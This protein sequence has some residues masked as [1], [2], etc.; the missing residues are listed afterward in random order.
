[1]ATHNNIH[2]I[3]KH[4]GLGTTEHRH[5]NNVHGLFCLYIILYNF[6]IGKTKKSTMLEV[7]IVVAL[8]GRTDCKIY[9]M[10][11]AV[12]WIEYQLHRCDQFVKICQNVYSNLYVFI[13]ICYLSVKSSGKLFLEGNETD[14][15]KGRSMG[16]TET[17]TERWWSWGLKETILV[18][19]ESKK[20]LEAY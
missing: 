13:Y 6:K 12:S 14:Y 19:R 10:D 16:R 4:L 1:M 11:N 9:T 3:H 15:F 17:V 2:D 5:K 20:S 8:E 7:R 18:P